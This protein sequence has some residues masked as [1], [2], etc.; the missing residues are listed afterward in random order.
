MAN[1]TNPN[2]YGFNNLNEFFFANGNEKM[3]PNN[4]SKIINQNLNRNAFKK[5]KV[6]KEMEN[7]IA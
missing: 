2:G 4:L 5:S 1:G 7:F 3:N 6:R